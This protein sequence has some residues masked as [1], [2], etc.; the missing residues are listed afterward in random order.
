MAMKRTADV[1]ETGTKSHKSYNEYRGYTVGDGDKV[2]SEG[3][4]GV[5][6][7]RFIDARKPVKLTCSAP[8][9]IEDFRLD[10][11]VKTLLYDDPLQV[12]RKVK[13]GFGLGKTREHLT[14][15]EIVQK[16]RLGDDS[17]YLTTQY[18]DNENSE[19]EGSLGDEFDE[20]LLEMS[21]SDGDEN[22]NGNDNGNGNGNGNEAENADEN[23]QD[24]EE[25]DEE[26]E[27]L[28]PPATDAF[29]DDD[30]I[31]LA[32]LHDDFEEDQNSEGEDGDMD[33]EDIDFRVRSLFQPPLTSLVKN[34]EFPITPKP[35]ENLIT[36][37]INLWMGASSK[38][39]EKPDFL[40]PTIENLGR[41]VPQGNS[42]GLHHDHADNLYVLAQG[43]KRFTLYLPNDAAKLYTVGDIN[44]I[45]GNGLI[46]YQVN[47]SAR[48]WRPMREDGAIKAEW[49]RWALEKEVDSGFSQSELEAMIEN[50]PQYSG[51]VD[52]SLDPP[53]FST[54]PPILAHLDEVTD[55]KERKALEEF[56]DKEFPGF[57][58]LRKLEVWLEPGKML[59]IPTGWF[60]E[61][62]SYASDKE[63][64]HV[65]LNWWFM[66]PSREI[67]TPYVDEYWA[68]DYEITELAI[69][70]TRED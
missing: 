49:A 4:I 30:S 19:D 31:D 10:S 60:H 32:N 68:D 27:S 70:L 67:K 37:Q 5:F 40:H 61:V 44:K 20:G 57:R 22:E 16:L 63:S 13:Y 17:Y 65:A 48:H 33:A 55:A 9:A 11:I 25:D 15:S 59:Y 50:E 18:E 34:E 69:Q 46:D 64:A 52:A 21:D 36:Q 53:S 38:S 35:F 43:K 14:L 3:D 8:V 1:T 42:S 54:V 58:Q 2:L 62:T 28:L 39:T 7:L 41:Y 12:E 66:P 56:A 26:E 24:D 47:K 29:S 45:Y 6:R 51:E 23:E